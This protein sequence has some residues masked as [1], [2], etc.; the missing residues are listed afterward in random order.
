M[1][2]TQKKKLRLKKINIASMKEL[3]SIKG[4]SGACSGP[5]TETYSLLCSGKTHP[6]YSE[7]ILACISSLVHC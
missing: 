5:C 1:R 4:K 3:Q 6:A 2:K 7:N